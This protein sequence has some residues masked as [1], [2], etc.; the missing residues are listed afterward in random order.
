MGWAFV[1]C[2]S[3]QSIF[4]AKDNTSFRS[5]DG[6]LYNINLTEIIR[7]PQNCQMSSFTIPNSVTK[8]GNGAFYGCTSLQ[9]IDIPNSVTEIGDDAF[10]GCTSL[11][12]IDIPNSVTE[13]GW[14]DFW[15]CTSLQSIVYE[16]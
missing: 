6:V 12:S 2:S 3:L 14:I 10:F 1:G 11:E 5:V 16:V 8:I 7:V 4:V 13:I 9:S 15:G